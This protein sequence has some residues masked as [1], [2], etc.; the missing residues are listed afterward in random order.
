MLNIM[1]TRFNTLLFTA[2]SAVILTSCGGSGTFDISGTIKGHEGKKLYLQKFEKGQPVNMDSTT[3]G[4]DGTFEIA[5]KLPYTDYYRL[6]LDQQNAFVFIGD[7]VGEL[8]ITAEENMASPTAIEGQADTKLLYEFDNNLRRLMNKGDSLMRLSEQGVPKEE[9]TEKLSVFNIE[10]MAYLH[11]FID[12]NVSSPAALAGLNKLN[13]V[14]DL[15][16]FTKVRD[17]LAVKMAK[18]EYFNYLKSQIDQASQQAEMMK[19][20]EKAQAENDKLLAVGKPVPTINLPDPSGRKRSLQEFRG[21]VVLIDFWASWCKPCRAEN[22]N[23]VKAYEQFKGKGFEVFSVSLDKSKDAW[24]RA[25]IE[26]GLRW[27]H[28]SDLQF[29]NSEAARAYGVQGIP[30]AVLIDKDGNII[31]KNLRGEALI[32]KLKEV[33]G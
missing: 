14:E 30:F 29:W 11:G 32:Q 6:A 27:T 33:L 19:M 21:K 2:L 8:A 9:V 15:A 7:S 17:G 13:P 23:V 28:V 18:S 26:D 4:T 22:P 3:I 16:Y 25:I 12:K 1:T 20:Q 10:A 31:A 5:A 24:E